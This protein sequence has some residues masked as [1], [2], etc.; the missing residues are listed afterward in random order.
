[1]YCDIVIIFCLCSLYVDAGCV[2]P[3]IVFACE[4][5]SLE[6]GGGRG[7]GGEWCFSNDF[8]F[9]LCCFA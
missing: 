3:Y 4:V 7:G 2:D 5:M 8:Y 1:M 9:G 6:E